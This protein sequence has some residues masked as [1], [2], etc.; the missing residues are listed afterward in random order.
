[1]ILLSIL[2][3]H[4]LLLGLVLSPRIARLWVLQHDLADS[5]SWSSPPLVLLRAILLAD[6]DCA[7]SAPPQSRPG[8]GA[9][10]G[11]SS[12]GGVLQHHWASP[13]SLPQLNS[14]VEA[15][16]MRGED[17]SNITVIPI[18]SAP[19]HA[20]L[21]QHLKPFQVL[22]QTF[23]VSLH[24]VQSSSA[25]TLSPPPW[26]RCCVR[27]WGTWSLW[28]KTPRRTCFGISPWSGLV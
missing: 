22:K 1:M 12:Q 13:L 20:Q 4:V 26:T 19:P 18:D 14:L 7:D 8:A 2:V 28:N 5:S 10:G 23:S 27:R 16:N 15:Y 3:L 24:V 21:I 6:F 9:R 11:R 17:A 25:N